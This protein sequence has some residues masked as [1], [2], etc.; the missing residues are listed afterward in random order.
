MPVSFVSEYP[1]EQEILLRG[2]LFQILR[3]YEEKAGNH[4]VHVVEMVMLNA[5]RDHGSEL[6][7][8]YGE[9]EKQRKHVG[10]ICA[11]TKYEICASLAEKYELDEADGYR[12]LAESTLKILSLDGIRT[13]FDS[14]ITE[15]WSV[16]RP[17]WIGASLRASFPR[18]YARRRDRF[19]KASYG[20]QDWEE[21]Q[22]IIDQEY[23]WQRSR[24]CNVTRLFGT[25]S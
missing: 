24:W 6:A 4:T 17:S 9:K 14:T 13:S 23:E 3:L 8:H 15:S 16:P 2:P 10:G 12:S 1:N 5:N 25:I 11:A 19:S 18:H 22:N 21:V 7:E 20:G